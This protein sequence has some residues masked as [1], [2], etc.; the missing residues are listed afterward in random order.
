MDLSI[1]LKE[2]TIKFP[3]F[4]QLMLITKLITL[5]FIP[6]KFNLQNFN[7]ILQFVLIQIQFNRLLPL[8]KLNTC[9]LYIFLES[10]YLLAQP[11]V[12]LLNVDYAHGQL[13]LRRIL[14]LISINQLFMIFFLCKSFL[15]IKLG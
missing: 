3:H 2:K 5:I 13:A 7:I 14:I 10:L 9:R 4:P 15:D 11:L 8:L 1:V 12:F 6:N